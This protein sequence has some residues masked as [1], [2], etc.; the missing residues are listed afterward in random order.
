[1]SLQRAA[2]E[3]RLSGVESAL[4]AVIAATDSQ[5]KD[6]DEDAGKAL[7]SELNAYGMPCF[8]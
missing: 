8:S 2:D 1:M 5:S 3:E 7:A 6:A 4:D